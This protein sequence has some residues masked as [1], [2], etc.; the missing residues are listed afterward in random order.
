VN[1]TI[2]LIAASIGGSVALFILYVHN[3]LTAG[4]E[5]IRARVAPPAA[6]P[7]QV[8]SLLRREQR[9]GHPL[10]R[11]MPV[12]RAAAERISRELEQA[13]WAIRVG[14]YQSLR[15]L[16]AIMLAVASYLLASV[17]GIDAAWLKILAVLVAAFIGWRIP[18]YYLARRRRKRLEQIEAQLPDTLISIVKSLRTGMGLLQALTYAAEQTPA[19]LGTEL[20]SAIRDLQFGAAAED[21]FSALSERVGSKDLDIV[22]TAIIIQRTVGGNLSE[23]LSTV[24]TTIRERMQLRAEVRILTAQQRMSANIIA[25]IPIGIAAAFILVNTGL[26]TVLFTTTYGQIALAVGIFF[27]VLGYWLVRRLAVIEA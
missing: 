4:E 7:P 8:G 27:E 22:V 26:G 12:S 14:E 5:M 20:Q 9:T 16:C 2:P 23:I 21:V 25:L 6:A 10:A 19:P 11:L 13:D 3:R 15:L 18:A 24:A 17:L 1:I